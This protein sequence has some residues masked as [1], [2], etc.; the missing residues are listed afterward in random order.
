[1]RDIPNLR[2]YDW[3]VLNSSSGKDSM[4]TLRHVVE[5]A[6][7]QG[8]DRS[9]LVVVHADLD[10][11]EWPGARSL[12]LH[13]ASLYG[14]RC[15]VEKRGQGDLLTHVLARGKW[16][17]SDCRYC[18]SDHKR[19]QISKVLTRLTVESG[20]RHVRILNCLGLR[21]E[22][23][24]ARAKRC[25][26]ER[27]NRA[28]NGK[29]TVDNWLPIHKWTT[30]QVWAD[31]HAHEVPHHYAYDL[32]MP[33]LSCIFCIFSPR[34]ALLL[35]GE[36]NPDLLEE[37]VEVELKIKHTFR[38]ELAIAAIKVALEG[39]ERADARAIANWQM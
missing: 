28:S 38:K 34:A 18:T 7:R 16:P 6:D 22:E 31:I 26:F 17:S 39:G 4:T 15:E 9:R 35:A 24:P 23:S 25:P 5:M 27:N 14:L 33:R 19:D 12:A 36:H 10:R 3:I 30:G 32:G 1:M 20:D 29:R 2:T 13:Q 37:Y 8:V 21:A 11:I